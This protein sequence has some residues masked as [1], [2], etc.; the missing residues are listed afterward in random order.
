MD[1]SYLCESW[2]GL[3]DRKSWYFKP[4]TNRLFGSELIYHFYPQLV[5]TY[6]M[7]LPFSERKDYIECTLRTVYVELEDAINEKVAV[8]SAASI[9]KKWANRSDKE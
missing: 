7:C 4:K 6:A 1:G 3:Y 5:I 8:P 2:C 9:S